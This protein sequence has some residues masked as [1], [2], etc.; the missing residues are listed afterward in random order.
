MILSTE[1]QPLLALASFSRQR[2]RTVP[3]SPDFPCPSEALA[4]PARSWLPAQTRRLPRSRWHDSSIPQGR[5]Y[6]ARHL[7]PARVGPV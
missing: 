4:N 6:F 2:P 5:Y 1:A 3:A 7:E